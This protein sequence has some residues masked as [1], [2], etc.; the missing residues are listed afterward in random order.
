MGERGGGRGERAAREGSRT[1]SPL[2][3]ALGRRVLER[4]LKEGGGGEGVKVGCRRGSRVFRK[5]I[6]AAVSR[7][8]RLEVG[9]SGE[10]AP[11]R[12]P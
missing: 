4:L 3:R 8:W 11:C 1:A 12:R 6:G 9:V 2:R 10:F 5:N 7:S